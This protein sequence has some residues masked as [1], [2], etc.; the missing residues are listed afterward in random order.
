VSITL[1]LSL[2]AIGAATGCGSSSKSSSTST[3]AVSSKSS[4]FRVVMVSD[5]SGPTKVYGAIDAAALKGTAAY[6]NQRGGIIGHPIA[7]TVLNDNGDETTAVSVLDQYLASHPKPNMVFPGSSGIDAGGLIPLVKRDNILGFGVA[8]SGTACLTNAQTTCP[9]AFVAGGPAKWQGITAAAW[10]K[11]HHY[12]NVG[13]LQEEDAFSESET[14]P[15]QAALKTDGIKSTVA[16][17]SPTAVNVTPEISQLR[18]AGAQAIFAEVLAAPAGYAASGR[19]SLGLVSKVPLVFDPGGASE[20][21]TKLGSA[22]NL[23]NAYE[24]TEFENVP[25]LKVPARSLLIKYSKPYGGVTSQP[26][27]IGA[28]PWQVLITLRDAAEQAKSIDQS[29]LINALNNLSPQAQKDALNI[30]ARSVAF[31]KS[32]HENAA[33]LTSAWDVVPVGPVQNGLVR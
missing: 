17:F 22:A 20:D 9:T 6:L 31:T 8:D 32:V 10:F 11:Q 14:P 3:S 21:I 15:L 16:S 19:A 23:K 12:A 18:A 27:S 7:T 29:D 1:L 33:N 4:P 28:V 13:V 30:F 26:V 5:L 2:L 25:A 24:E